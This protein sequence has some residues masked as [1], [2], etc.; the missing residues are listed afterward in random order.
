MLDEVY[1]KDGLHPNEI[2]HQ[3]MSTRIKEKLDIYYGERRPNRVYIESDPKIIAINVV[4][5]LLAATT[6]CAPLPTVVPVLP[7][8]HPS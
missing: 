7:P 3:K 8:I 1:T 5:C 2:G 4:P 6:K